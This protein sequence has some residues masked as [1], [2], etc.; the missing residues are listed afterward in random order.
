MSTASECCSRDTTA[1]CS[2]GKIMSG[3]MVIAGITALVWWLLAR[4]A[5]PEELDPLSETDRRIGSLEESL[6]HLQDSF[7]QRQSD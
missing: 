4:R 6:H 1:C 5:E 2:A 3:I 7:G